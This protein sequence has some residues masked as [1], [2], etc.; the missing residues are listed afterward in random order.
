MGLK[1]AHPK[2]GRRPPGRDGAGRTPYPA[3]LRPGAVHMRARAGEVFTGTRLLVALGELS[4]LASF[5][6]PD[7]NL[8]KSN[9][10]SCW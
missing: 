9:D 5:P 10:F 2:V 4:S 1:S 7:L 3:Q 8:W 6:F